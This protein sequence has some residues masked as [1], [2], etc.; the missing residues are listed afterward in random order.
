MRSAKVSRNTLETQIVVELNLDGSGK[1]GFD[2]GRRSSTT[3]STR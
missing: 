2:T 1:A 3:C